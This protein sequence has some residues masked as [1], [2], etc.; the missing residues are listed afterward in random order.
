MKIRC[1]LFHQFAVTAVFGNADTMVIILTI[2]IILILIL[3]IVLLLIMEQAQ[4]DSLTNL[5]LIIN[6]KNDQFSRSLTHTI[7]SSG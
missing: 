6:S 4:S 2:S 7:Q 3:T 5:A 1:N